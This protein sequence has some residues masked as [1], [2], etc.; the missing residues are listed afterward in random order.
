MDFSSA[1]TEPHFEFR[2][3]VNSENAIKMNRQI[4]LAAFNK[5][6][7]EEVEYGYAGSNRTYK[8]PR[9]TP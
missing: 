2:K 5:M 7:R 6:V 1:W 8:N 3:D 4:D 9:S